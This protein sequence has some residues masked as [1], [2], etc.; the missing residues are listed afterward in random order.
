MEAAR[1]LT[2]ARAPVTIIGKTQNKLEVHDLPV[3]MPQPH[4]LPPRAMELP[5]K[6]PSGLRTSRSSRPDWP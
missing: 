3:G 4:Q 6:V 1:T 2:A 5:S